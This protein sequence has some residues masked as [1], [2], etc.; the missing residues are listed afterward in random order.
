MRLTEPPTLAAPNTY[1]SRAWESTVRRIRRLRRRGV[2][3]LVTHADR[4]GD[5]GEVAVCGFL[6]V[7]VTEVDASATRAEL[8]IGV[9]Q[10]ENRVDHCPRQHD[11]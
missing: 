6:Y 9:A 4:E 2:G 8:L 1:D 7:R 10:G 3:D 5:V 11:G